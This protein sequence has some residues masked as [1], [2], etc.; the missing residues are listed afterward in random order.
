MELIEYVVT[1]DPSTFGYILRVAAQHYGRTLYLRRRLNRT[2][3]KDEVL[4]LLKER[5]GW[6]NDRPPATKTS[7]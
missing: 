1:D 7:P 4:Q 5:K 3:T 6:A 2:P